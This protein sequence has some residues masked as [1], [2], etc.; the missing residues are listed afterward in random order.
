M[1]TGWWVL[2][3]NPKSLCGGRSP[4]STRQSSA[5]NSDVNPLSPSSKPSLQRNLDSDGWIFPF[6]TLHFNSSVNTSRRPSSPVQDDRIAPMDLAPP[7][8]N[9]PTGKAMPSMPSRTVKGPPPKRPPRP[10]SLFRDMG[11]PSTELP[12]PMPEYLS[13]SGIAAVEDLPLWVRKLGPSGGPVINATE[14]PRGGLGSH[15]VDLG[16]LRPLSSG[17]NVAE[18]SDAV[19]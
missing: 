11:L 4:T 1:F 5:L 13:Q 6:Q 8:K 14:V 18:M 10:V 9:A 12:P 7:E 15:P 3:K 16:K 2:L 17:N 19:G